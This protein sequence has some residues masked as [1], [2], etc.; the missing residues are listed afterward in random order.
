[1]PTVQIDAVRLSFTGK[2]IIETSLIVQRGLHPTLRQWVLPHTWPASQN[3]ALLKN[4][5]I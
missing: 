1:M 4:R 5:S 2:D 3:F